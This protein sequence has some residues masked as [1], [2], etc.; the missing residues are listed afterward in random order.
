MMIRI[1]LLVLLAALTACSGPQQEFTAEVQQK[2]TAEV[3]VYGGTPS[4]ISAAIALAKA[5]RSVVIVEPS[6][7]LGGMAG[8]GI[9]VLRDCL[10]AN[11]VGGIARMWM[12]RERDLGSTYETHFN[13]AEIRKLWTEFVAE[14]KIDVIYQH[15][16]GDVVKNGKKIEEL[17]LDYAP[18]AANGRPAASPQKAKA[19]RIVAEVYIDASYEGDLMAKSG[20]SY[21]IGR[22]SRDQ[23]NESLGGQGNVQAF[24]I[25]PYVVPDD[26]NSGLLPMIDTDP[27]EEGAASRHINAFNFRLQWVEGGTPV[28][29]PESIDHEKYALVERALKENKELVD[30]P[31]D[32]YERYKMISGGIP[33]RQADFPDADWPERSAIWQEWIDYVKTLN[34]LTGNK[35]GLKSGEYPESDDF[36]NA[37]YIRQGRRMIGE[38]VMTQHDL[39]LQTDI[40]NPIGLAYHPVDIY[41]PRLIA[42]PDGKVANEGAIMIMASPGPYQVPYE[43]LTPKRDECSNL[44]VP[45]CMSSSHV[46]MAA[47]RIEV[48]YMVMGEAAGIAA[49]R[50]LAEG[51]NVQDI[52]MSGLRKDLLDAGAILQ[53]DGKSYGDK[54]VNNTST[55][56]NKAH[57]WDH[58]EDYAK[59][60]YDVLYKGER[61]R[62]EMWFPLRTDEWEPKRVE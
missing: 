36:P 53:W 13:Q 42:T 21:A 3:C 57:W 35:M 46:A 7:W 41:P 47:N 18:P 55:Y 33:G 4:G 48:P 58:P 34:V 26:P 12:E 30:W 59:R 28:P 1:F 39:M 62:S 49:A 6:R 16:L 10:Y 44:L 8:G 11:D 32:N 2:F 9:G 24:D 60:P 25:S 43:S 54:F 14:Y 27:Y 40:E 45:V 17:L 29:A 5:N 37:L 19:L 50:A 61:K 38:Y 51:V 56:T 20:V 22:E 23:Y 15:R 31:H 52:S